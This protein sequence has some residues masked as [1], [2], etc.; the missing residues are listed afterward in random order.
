MLANRKFCLIR[1][2]EEL[3][4]EVFSPLGRSGTKSK[5]EEHVGTSCLHVLFVE[6][7]QQKILV[8]LDKSLRINL[9]VLELLIPIP[10]NSL[11]KSS[12]SHLLPP[13]QL[14]FLTL[15]DVVNCILLTLLLSLLFVITNVVQLLGLFVSLGTEQLLHFLS[16]VH[17]FFGKGD[18]DTLFLSDLVMQLLN[19]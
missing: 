4:F 5:S 18:L 11:Q 13:S 7:V 16:H 8:P 3:A 2:V 15:N 19:L 14:I 10:L 1:I 6:Q 9:P 17:K 12:K